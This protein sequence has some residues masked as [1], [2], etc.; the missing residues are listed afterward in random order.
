LQEDIDHFLL[1]GT[2]LH[3]EWFLEGQRCPGGDHRQE[4]PANLTERPIAP[5][6]FPEARQRLDVYDGCPNQFAY[7]D[8][9]HQISVWRA[10]TARWAKHRLAEAAAAVAVATSTAADAAITA[11]AAAV[12]TA[13]AAHSLWVQA[14][15]RATP[16]SA[17]HVASSATVH[18][19]STAAAT[20]TSKLATSAV[21]TCTAATAVSDAA[22]LSA[23]A[24]SAAVTSATT[25]HRL[26]VTASKAATSAAAA[27]AAAV[28]SHQAV[29]SHAASTAAKA[30]D[31]SARAVT[32]IEAASKAISPPMEVDGVRVSRAAAAAVAAAPALDGIVRMAIKLVE[33]HGKS[34]CDGNSNTPV[35][36]L[37]HAL[38]HGLIGPNP[39]TRQLVLWLAEH[40]PFTSTPKAEKRG[41]EAI[42]R[43]FYGFMNTDRFTK[44]VVPDA[45][46][47]K[48]SNSSKHHSFVGRS[49]SSHVFTDGSLQACHEFCP[50]CECLLGR[51]NSCTLK[52]EMGVMH[53]ASVPWVSG[54]PL[55]KLEE[56]AA[57]G[58]LL[59]TGMIV[60]FTA[61]AKDVWMEG[62][63]WLA[64]I[65]GP[66]HPVPEEQARAS[67]LFRPHTPATHICLA[68]CM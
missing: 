17:C 4:L 30:A 61:H 15:A 6:D 68:S 45:D 51:Y 60:A 8:Q 34:G 12:T 40:K 56:L 7:G 31:A 1:H 48:F 54:P 13:T 44:T 50:C 19:L 33:H 64:L 37:K 36:A 49:T 16:N 46:G 59:K 58:E 55:R 28:P 14:A 3:G 38:E 10:K 39:G 9:Y 52:S 26:A 57:W 27:A 11:S 32:A 25:T 41:W 67:L 29:L 23:S 35:L 66:A 5:A 63:Y 43:I 2:F 22:V 62:S 18:R 42:G 21:A 53:A 24:A 20:A 47:S 65:C